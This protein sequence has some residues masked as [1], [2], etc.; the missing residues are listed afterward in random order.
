M[1]LES[2][3]GHLL[4]KNPSL[5][6][7]GPSFI[8]KEA[9]NTLVGVVVDSLRELGRSKLSFCG[10]GIRAIHRAQGIIDYQSVSHEKRAR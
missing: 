1:P 3:Q 6:P 2:L 8:I 9:R 5:I 4:Y 10:Q 7:P